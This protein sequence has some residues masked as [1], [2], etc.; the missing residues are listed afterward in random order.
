MKNDEEEEET[1]TTT[2]KSTAAQLVTLKLPDSNITNWQ[3]AK[4]YC[5]T[6]ACT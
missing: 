1:T 6:H 3:S 2:K 4:S 5:S